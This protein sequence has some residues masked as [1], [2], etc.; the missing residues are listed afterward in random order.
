VGEGL[1]SEDFLKQQVC[2]FAVIPSF[3]LQF[4]RVGLKVFINYLRILTFKVF[5]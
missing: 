3:V 4:C 2:L 1:I 5:Y